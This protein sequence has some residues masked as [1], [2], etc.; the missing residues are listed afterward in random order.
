[1][2]KFQRTRLAHSPNGS[3]NEACQ[4]LVNSAR[5]TFE[6][7]CKKRFAYIKTLTVFIND[8]RTLINKAKAYNRGLHS[9]AHT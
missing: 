6:R 7:C 8:N 5:G 9:N 2:S 3:L 4:R 1:M